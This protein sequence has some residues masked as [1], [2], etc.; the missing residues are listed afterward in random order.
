MSQYRIMSLGALR[1]ALSLFLTAFVVISVDAVGF[2][3][4]AHA[5][6]VVSEI[7][8]IGNRRVEPETV[9]SY[10]KFTTGDVYDA[11]RV[12]QSLRALFATGLFADVEIFR[13]GN[14]VRVRVEENPVINQVAFEGNS[15]V[16]TNTLQAEV[17]LK[18]RSIYTRARV[19]ADVQRI[20]DVYSRQ[21]RYAA[22]VEPK[23]IELEQN[24]VNLVF[25][26]M[27]GSATKVK[28][29][30]F[31]GNRA[32]S[33]AQLR[34]IISTTQA[35]WFDF[36]S[37]TSIYDPDRMNLDREL[38]RQ[39]YLKNGYADARVTSANAEL[40]RD[41]SG[42]FLTFTVE[43][44]E[45]YH[46]G[47]IVI[48]S[49]LTGLDAASLSG[50]LLTYSG[51]VYNGS[52]LDK[53]VER[54]TLAVAERGFAFARVRP[55]ATPDMYARTIAINYVID[56]GPRVYIER[57]NISGNERTKDH[58]IRREFRL[59]EGDAF[60][61]LMVDRAEK[62]LK[63]LGFFKAV[64]VKRRPGSAPD[65]V[66]L[67]VQ[68][69]EQSTGELSFG[70]GYSTAEGVIGD[71]SISE[72]NLL[73]NGQYIRLRV[74]GSIERAQVDLSFTEPR[75]LDRNLSA[76]F[77]LYHKELDQR[78]QSGFRSRKSGGQLRLGFPLS[79]DLWMQTSYSLS[80]D[81]IFDVEDDASLA[82]KDACGDTVLAT[83]R[84]NCGDG[85]YWT[86]SAGTMITYD[87]RNHPT[88]P[89]SGYYLQGTADFA[90]LGGDA[91]YVRVQAEARG[92]YPV[93]ENITFVSR[94]VG[95]HI[96][97][98]G[99]EDVRV[100]DQFFRGGETVRG[101]DRSGFGPRDARTGDALGGKTYWAA[102]AE[103]RFPI[104]FVPEELGLGGAVFADAGSL[105]NASQ[106]V[107]DILGNNLEDDASVR[108]SV[109]ASLLW[110]SPV[111]PLRVDFSKVL[112]SEEYDDE[113]WFRFGAS[114]KF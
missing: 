23:I 112:A 85:T 53:T 19:Q 28:S 101:F 60:N 26:I 100:L 20:L 33:D 75:F 67:D 25:E 69:T 10:L 7:Q 68:V 43:E 82:I 17:Q 15:E 79:E 90:G 51:D 35:G 71:V 114:S 55:R 4:P 58:V 83:N 113:Q 41:G 80:R 14:V 110:N 107:K 111:G 6:V 72:R 48:D 63:A 49:S 54:L 87:K 105:F 73:G 57:I 91:E 50:D 12:D 109:G 70:A 16:D 64:D 88:N 9:R 32:F 95:G 108:A 106:H 3:T 36:L 65:R 24:R 62:R 31:I 92:Y 1:V 97:G 104:P 11:G 77:D 29:I 94:V 98:W 21:G 42:F 30:N 8:V 59:A 84:A 52:L 27:E 103:L 78:D 34:D 56:E 96:E 45:L 74:G 47:N 40:D 81:Q 46:F 44:G 5:Q 39:Y 76:G 102:T 38:L 99:D 89:T 93:T 22:N 61:P 13:D 37:G 18:P 86:S 2:S 66:V